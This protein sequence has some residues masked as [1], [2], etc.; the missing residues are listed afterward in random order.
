PVRDGRVFSATGVIE[1]GWVVR[2][3]LANTTLEEEDGQAWY[4]VERGDTLW[5]IS[6]RFLGDPLR[7]PELF[8]ANRGTSLP[9]GRTLT[10]PNL[11]WPELRL[12]VPVDLESAE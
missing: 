11:I 7:W 1:P 9:D 4:S 10:N 12:R 2:V 3:P 8:E 5:G 6:A